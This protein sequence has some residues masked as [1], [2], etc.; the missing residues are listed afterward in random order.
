VATRKSLPGKAHAA[1]SIWR[2]PYDHLTQQKR[3]LS[4]KICSTA[5]DRRRPE[6]ESDV[7]APITAKDLPAAKF[8]V[9]VAGAALEDVDIRARSGSHAIIDTRQGRG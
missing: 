4:R 9:V 3:G 7:V 8:K 6:R 5:S 2:A 1:A